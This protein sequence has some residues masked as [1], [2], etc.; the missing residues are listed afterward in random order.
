M[1]KK[2]WKFIL[3]ERK[4]AT[5]ATLTKIRHNHP[6]LE[7]SVGF[8]NGKLEILNDLLSLL[9]EEEKKE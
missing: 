5:E 7:Y 3:N 2:Y 9:E 8:G 4:R 1:D 6:E